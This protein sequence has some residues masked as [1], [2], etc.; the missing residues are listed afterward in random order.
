MLV[1]TLT[2]DNFFKCH[3]KFNGKESEIP[4]FLVTF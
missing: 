3:Q 4:N 1:N 2:A